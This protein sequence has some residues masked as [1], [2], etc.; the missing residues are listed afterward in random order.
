[1]EQYIQLESNHNEVVS[2]IALKIIKFRIS[3]NNFNIYD[4]TALRNTIYDR[5]PLHYIVISQ[6]TNKITLRIF[7]TL[8]K[9]RNCV[10][11]CDSVYGRYPI[12]YVASGIHYNYRNPYYNLLFLLELGSLSYCG[13][14]DKDKIYS[15][16]VNNYIEHKPQIL[17][18]MS[19]MYNKIAY[20]IQK[21][22][23]K[24]KIIY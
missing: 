5:N 12:H 13:F 14:E 16:S 24:K 21:M 20:K 10:R 18:V 2:L 17:K 7:K 9:N 4:E 6:I 22:Y 3:K 15:K 11:H 23:K 1:M 19:I 8:I